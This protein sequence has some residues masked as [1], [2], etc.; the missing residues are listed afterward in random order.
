MEVNAMKNSQNLTSKIK[1]ALYGF[2][3]GDAMGATTEFMDEKQ[4]KRIYGKVDNI[5]GGGWLHLKAGEVTDDTQM[6]MCVCEAIEFGFGEV[7]NWSY[8][9]YSSPEDA[10]LNRC[11]N[12]FI[13]WLLTNPKDIGGCCNRVISAFVRKKS[14]KYKA[15]HKK[16]D[17]PGSL[18]NGSLMRTMPIVL[19][20]L[21]CQ[22]ALSQGRLTHN[23][24]PCDYA[25][26]IYYN[27][28]EEL[29][30]HDTFRNSTTQT[31]E[32][33]GHVLNTLN[34]ALYWA[35]H[36]DSL[37]QAIIK[38]VNHGGDADTIAAITGSMAGALYGYEAIPQR[39]I[40]QL[41]PKVKA[42]LDRYTELFIKLLEKNVKKVCTNLE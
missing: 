5:I 1:G 23:N 33:T 32:P 31:Y 13:K 36:T 19:A 41:D 14:A 18:G 27:N 21:G 30:Y 29:L 24:K 15:W 22:A 42:D 37:E 25:L 38:A 35:Q 2:A 34:N 9:E 8:R 12:N 28:M 20:G 16:A 39:W 11:C 10:M 26:E 17:D 4:I 40:E 3:I 6:T 7:R